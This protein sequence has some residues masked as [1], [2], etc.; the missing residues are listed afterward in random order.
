MLR[1]L[2][3]PAAPAYATEGLASDITPA[4]PPLYDV[5]LRGNPKDVESV[6]TTLRE[7]AKKNTISRHQLCDAFMGMKPGG[8]TALHSGFNPERLGNLRAFLTQVEAAVDDKLLHASDLR[9]MFLHM[10]RFG[11]TPLQLFVDGADTNANSLL[12]LCDCLIRLRNKGALST[13]DLTSIVLAGR[14]GWNAFDQAMEWGRVP[15]AA[16]PALFKLAETLV[17]FEQKEVEAKKR[18]RSMF[19]NKLLQAL[20]KRSIEDLFQLGGTPRVTALIDGINGL[21]NTGTLDLG[22][23]K[24]VMGKALATAGSE[25][26]PAKA[27]ERCQKQAKAAD[28]DWFSSAV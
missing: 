24:A 18:G 23:L 27:R 13:D 8:R 2:T 5:M 3:R 28:E 17:R 16:T 1:F 4:T 25:V 15:H 10:D 21:R 19:A 22:I 12:A 9:S 20:D 26:I 11:Q 6:M 14:E 7:Q